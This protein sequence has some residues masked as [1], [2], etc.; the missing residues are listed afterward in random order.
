MRKIVD[1][2]LTYFGANLHSLP[3]DHTN[4]LSPIVWVC[5]D[6]YSL[7]RVRLRFFGGTS[8]GAH[9]LTNTTTDNDSNHDAC[10]KLP[11]HTKLPEPSWPFEHP[12]GSSIKKQR[13][14]HTN[15]TKATHDRSG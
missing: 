12:P 1:T 13:D 10:T 7:S 11:E 4:A 15:E 6:F 3:V 8:L 9:T 14:P 5:V 2:S